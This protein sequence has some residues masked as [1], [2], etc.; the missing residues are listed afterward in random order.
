MNIPIRDLM[1]PEGYRGDVPVDALCNTPDAE[2]FANVDINI[3]RDLLTLGEAPAHDGVAL[4]C[5]G[6]PS[7][8]HDIE[9]IRARQRNGAVIFA[10]NDVGHYLRGHEIDPEWLVIIDC[11]PENIR[12]L[13]GLPAKNYLLSP[14]C[15]PALYDRL[16]GQNVV[17]LIPAIEGMEA[18]IP[19]KFHHFCM[20]GGGITVGL[21]A[22]AAAYTMGF[23][24]L[25]LYGYDSSDSDDGEA[26][27]YQQKQSKAES[28]RLDAWFQGRKFRCSFAMYAQADGFQRF[29]QML[30][31]EGVV[32]SVHGDGLLPSIAREMVRPRDA[33]H[34]VY[35]LG[36]CPA[37]YDFVDWLIQAEMIRRAMEAPAPLK[38][39]F[40]PGPNGG[41]RADTLPVDIAGRQRFLDNVMRPALALVGAIEDGEAPSDA[42]TH[43][44]YTLKPVVE[45]V[46]AGVAVPRWR[47][48]DAAVAAVAWWLTKRAIDQA[49]VVITL[50]ESTH[51]PQRN[52]RLLNWLRFADYLKSQGE[53]VVIV[54]DTERAGD[55]FGAHDVYQ[56][57]A[58]HLDI[59]AALYQ[60]AK[61]NLMSSNGAGALPL[62]S[63]VPF[64]IFEPLDVPGY[65]PACDEW[66]IANHGINRGEQYPWLRPDQ[67]I[68]WDWDSYS[69]IRRAWDDLLPLLS[70]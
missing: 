46:N 10:L 3:K 56:Q 50:R 60:C 42:C 22:M 36:R 32:I 21:T 2:L 43:P 67:R 12:F 1:P 20:I 64:L 13:D 35:D 6:G 28:K 26:H 30:A 69:A 37:S 61:C 38:V 11:R 4:L 34:A 47:A 63:N 17:T 55:A 33:G 54:R 45:M 48:E 31:N 51:W 23:R 65:G 70:R 8:E 27:A 68:V 66:W 57:A 15:D 29:S 49:P 53:A 9:E 40:A 52:S 19:A 44:V 5:G 62:F 59:R 39:T 24:D 14:Q 41:F 7:I 58:M 25:H 16:A 18:R